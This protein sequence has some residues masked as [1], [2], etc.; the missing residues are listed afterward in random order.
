[1]NGYLEGNS[2]E[3]IKIGGNHA[4]AV[5]EGKGYIDLTVVMPVYNERLVV[6]ESI[7]RTI[8]VLNSTNISY[9]L[10]IV[11]DGSIDGTSQILEKFKNEVVVLSYGEN[12]GKGYALK[13]GTRN[14][15]GEV[16]AFFDS[17]LNIEPT[18][19][20]DY[21]LSMKSKN[22][23]IV[24]GSKRMKTSVV[25]ISFERK[26]LS[27]L[28]HIFAKALLGLEVMDS[29]VGLKLFKRHI[30]TEIIPL[31]VVD[32]YAFDVELLV[33][34]SRFGYRTVELP[35][36]IDMD[37]RM[38]KVNVKAIKKMFVD[39]LKIVYKLRVSRNL[40][41]KYPIQEHQMRNDVR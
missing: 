20:V 33:L 4:T 3:K 7:N 32:S 39:T 36:S 18:Y 34:A 17:D 10:I 38:S 15:H 8:E 11:D 19:I 35:V 30:L 24:V 12:K 6:T 14:A 25:R 22:I 9:E 2:K 23:D 40:N 26:I 13:Y 28:Y 21:F 27:V 29:Q 5:A 41:V 37:G 31:M 1:M 16:I